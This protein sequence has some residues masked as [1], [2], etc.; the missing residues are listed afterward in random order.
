MWGSHDR[1]EY[2]TGTQES[3]GE[4]QRDQ[5]R[6]GVRALCTAAFVG[7]RVRYSWSVCCPTA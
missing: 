6:Q 1:T 7:V 2:G 5:R 3:V 4:L